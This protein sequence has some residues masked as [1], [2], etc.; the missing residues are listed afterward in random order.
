MTVNQMR[1]AIASVYSGRKWKVKVAHMD[2]GQVLAIYQDFMRKG[3]FDVERG[4]KAPVRPK[5][6]EKYKNTYPERTPY[7]TY[8]GKQISIFDEAN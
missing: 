1:E 8:S 4:H 6:K 7:E 3:K 5:K 2:D